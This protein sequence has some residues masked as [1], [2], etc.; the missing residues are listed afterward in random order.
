M[1][2]QYIVEDAIRIQVVK[3]IQRVYRFMFGVRIVKFAEALDGL[4]K[5]LSISFSKINRS[6][7]NFVGSFG[8]GFWRILIRK[9]HFTPK[10]TTDTLVIKF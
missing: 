3:N 5:Y 1:L 8:F 7:K 9:G 6:Y 4:Q 2:L 10:Q